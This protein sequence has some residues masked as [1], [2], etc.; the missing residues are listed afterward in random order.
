M[1]ERTRGPLAGEERSLGELAAFG[2]AL[3]WLAML[4]RGDGHPVLVIPGFR[5]SDVSTVPLRS[6]LQWLGY[7][8]GGWGLGVNAG[9]DERTMRGV[10]ERLEELHSAR[11]RK[12]SLVGWSL[13]GVYARALARRSPEQV[14]Q[15]ITLGSPFRSFES[16]RRGRTPPVP[17]TAIY[18][19]TDPIVH[20]TD[21]MEPPGPQ[22]ESIEVRGSH[23]GLG[24]N[25]AVAVAVA[26]R[27]AQREGRW[28][29]FQV[30]ATLR[31]LF[32]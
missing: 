28:R 14:R 23:I 17:V 31:Q 29:P 20:W 18:S 22:A 10:A 26:D 25:P 21:A 5:A 16:A 32:P 4:P 11:G 30:P 12:V 3:P 27:L 8:V 7:Q 2:A 6:L 1:A 24:H 15:V 9:P 13:G 19:R